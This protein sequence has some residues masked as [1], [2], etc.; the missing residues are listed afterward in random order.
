[1]TIQHPLPASGGARTRLRRYWWVAG[2]AIAALV[3]VILAPLASSHPDGLERVAEDKEFLDT[4]K[5]ARWEWLPDYSV[6]G[7][8]GDASTVLAGL[9][10]VAIV[11]ALMVLAGRMLSRRSQ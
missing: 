4:A 9:I 5:G 11:F 6:P 3:V 2:V 8:S 10:G 7:L 1:M